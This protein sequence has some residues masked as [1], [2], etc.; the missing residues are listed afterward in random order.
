M[1]VLGRLKK[2]VTIQY[3]VDSIIAFTPDH[4]SASNQVGNQSGQSA[5]RTSAEISVPPSIGAEGMRSKTLV[6]L[7]E[8]EA[9]SSAVHARPLLLLRGRLLRAAR[10]R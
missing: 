1:A 4:V 10:I 7:L 3:E 8:L 9:V 6:C 2:V 5:A